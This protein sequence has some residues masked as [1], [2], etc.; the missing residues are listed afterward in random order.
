MDN[1]IVQYACHRMALPLYPVFSQTFFSV[2]KAKQKLRQIIVKP[3]TRYYPS[4]KCAD[5]NYGSH[6]NISLPIYQPTI[7]THNFIE[8]LDVNFPI[9][10]REEVKEV[11]KKG[12]EL[13]FDYKNGGLSIFAIA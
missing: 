13:N 1:Q 3:N 5:K 12:M 10:S 9:N 4:I 11:E 7:W 2:Y 8:A 6:E